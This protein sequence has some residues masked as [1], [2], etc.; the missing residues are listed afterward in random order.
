MDR[1]SVRGNDRFMDDKEFRKLRREDLIEIIYQYQRREQRLLQENDLLKRQLED[2]RIRI[3]KTGS[4]AEASLALSG[5]FEAAQKAAD[6]YLQSVK[7]MNQNP[8]QAPAEKAAEQEKPA[9][10]EKKTVPSEMAAKPEVPESASSQKHQK[11]PEKPVPALKPE[12]QKPAEKSADVP[13]KPAHPVKPVSE[14][15]EKAS[16]KHQTAEKIPSAQ[17]KTQ[18][19]E[20]A[21]KPAVQNPGKDEEKPQQPVKPAAKAPAQPTAK[22]QIHPS[23]KPQAQPTAKPQAQPTA[24]PPVQPSAKPQAQPTVKPQ[25]QPTVKSPVPPIAKTQ[26]SPIPKPQGKPVPNKKQEHPRPAAA[27]PQVQSPDTD[28]FIASLK[29]YLGM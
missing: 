13:E 27:K 23:A 14:D 6:L 20:K 2:R 3:Q 24:K 7:A 11:M 16:R 15:Q 17:K 4:I 22:P 1:L 9:A 25:A 5:I 8:E 21:E 19:P 18:M 28:E 12:Q 29:D 10:A 26:A